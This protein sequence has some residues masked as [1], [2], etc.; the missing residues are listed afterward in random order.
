MTLDRALNESSRLKELYEQD[1]EVKKVIDYALQIEGVPRHSSTHAAGVVIAPRSLT[2][3]IPLQTSDQEVTT[4]YPM[5]DLE[6]IGLLKMDF[7]GLRN[8][9]VIEH[10]L[11]S[12][13]ERG[14]ELEL[15]KLS[16]DD[17]HTYALLG[18]GRS[19]GV[20]QLESSGMQRI[21]QQLQPDCFADLVT[22]LAMYR[23]GPLGSGMV[24][25]FIE[26]RHGR[27]EV[28]YP[29]PVLEPI[30]SETYGV[31]LY[32]EQVMQI[33]NKMAGYSMAEADQLRRCMGKKKVKE[34][35]KHRQKF[36]N[37]AVEKDFS[38]AKAEEIFD[39]MAYFAGY[40]FNKSHSAAYALLAYQTAYLKA[41]YTT[42][43]MAALLSSVM[44][45][46]DKV[47][48]YLDDA[49]GMDIQVL[50]P[51]INESGYNFTVVEEGIRFGL[52][53]VKNVGSS[54]I[55]SIIAARNREGSFSSLRDF[56]ERVSLS[57]VTNKVAESLIRC[58]AMDGMGYTRSQLLAGLED[59]Y[60]SIQ[61]Q[62]RE[63]L[64]G[65][66]SLLGGMEEEE[67]K[68][69][70]ALPEIDEFPKDELL[71]ME[72]ELLGFYLSGHPLDSYRQQLEKRVDCWSNE[73]HELPSDQSKVVVG[74]LL[75]D[76]RVITTK[77]GNE[78]A[79]IQL[80][81]WYGKLEVVLF[82]KSYSKI[83]NQLESREPFI[84]CGRLEKEDEQGAKVLADSIYTLEDAP[85][86]IKGKNNG[87]SK[88]KNKN[89][90]NKG[91]KKKQPETLM[92]SIKVRE[93]K[94]TEQTL[95]Q[96]RRVLSENR[97]PHPVQIELQFGKREIIIAAGNR[98][99]IQRKDV[100][101][102]AL[103]QI[104]EEGCL[105]SLEWRG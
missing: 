30:L 72:R 23:P 32:Q 102:A 15:E 71:E 59:I 92:L 75:A 1:Q 36:I 33:A 27:A 2:G 35:E 39:L 18:R 77:N 14:E 25:D 37:G 49:Q 89:S 6:E 4:Q 60:A 40:G 22:L 85:L 70:V 79:F 91:K 100:V 24:D 88:M 43:Y 48:L 53:A 94:K 11:Q 55:E 20:F 51:D 3:Y 73:L 17:Q 8:L 9:T 81:D 47:A 7:L 74:G 64:K 5:G 93:L 83:S 57:K 44:D 86:Q 26:R 95:N 69:D 68:L 84:I 63:R 82:P 58:G 13:R 54:A 31:I 78:M 97:G 67:Q 87:K 103:Q 66:L 46:S 21:L 42:D 56:C 76:K 61:N 29:H 19:K 90:G 101:T 105:N 80:E 52:K 65:Q 45:N 50:P 12:I 10:T 96:I 98:Y 28:E 104:E 38:P 99:H 34:M 41:H 62:K 16:L